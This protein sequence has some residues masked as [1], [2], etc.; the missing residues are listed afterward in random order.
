MTDSQAQADAAIR[1]TLATYNWCGDNGDLDGFLATFSPDGVLDIKD[2]MVCTGHEQIRHALSNS[3]GATAEQLERRRQAGGRFS[4][5]VSS[6][7][8]E[9]TS[10][11]QARCWSYFAVVG[12]T[13]W[14]HWGRYTDHLHQMDGRWLFVRR[15]VSI[16]GHA[17]GS[18]MYQ[19]PVQA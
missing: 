1:Y 3:F 5:H 16:D 17:P 18:V 6:V 13:G 11:T 9:I 15:R 4:H 10:P 19:P 8:I 12:P 7:R 14:D 2:G